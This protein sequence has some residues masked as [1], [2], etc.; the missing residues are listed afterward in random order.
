VHVEVRVDT[1]RHVLLEVQ[2]Y[3]QE[4]L[5]ISGALLVKAFVREHAEQ[6]RFRHTNNELRH[7]GIRASM[8][9]R[10]FGTSGPSDGRG[11]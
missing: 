9:A 5:G 7:L 1:Q 8:I 11:S 2:V 3:L 4:V 6:A 10:R